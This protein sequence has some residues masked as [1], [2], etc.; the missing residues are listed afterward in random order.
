MLVRKYGRNLW[1]YMTFHAFWCLLKNIPSPIGF[2]LRSFFLNLCQSANGFVGTETRVDLRNIRSISLAN[3][4]FIESL[5]EINGMNGLIKIGE[6]AYVGRGTIINCYDYLNRGK[7]A[8]SIGA[9][10]YCGE[11]CN[12][13]GQGPVHIGDDVLLSPY[14]GIFPVDHGFADPLRPKNQQEIKATGI[15]IGNDVWIGAHSTVVDGVEIGDG[16][17]IGA[18]SVVRG[19]LEPHCLYAGVPARLVRTLQ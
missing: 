5:A 16:A 11:Y 17:I 10:F 6:R 15:R 1:H 9:R 7:A 13:R 14:V 4:C 2:L 3:N 8:I 18:G 19:K 12:I